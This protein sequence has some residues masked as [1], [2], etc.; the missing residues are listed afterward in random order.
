MTLAPTPAP[1]SARH[2]A[3][4][5]TADDKR[6]V[7]AALFALEHEIAASGAAGLAHEVAHARLQWWQQE[8]QQLSA[9]GARHP[10]AA[11]LE[12][13]AAKIGRPP[14]NLQPWTQAAGEQLARVAWLDRSELDAHLRRWTD[15]IWLQA[16]A[17]L[18]PPLAGEQAAFAALTAAGDA[19]REIELLGVLARDARQGR[20]YLPLDALRACNAQTSDCYAQ[21]WPAPLAQL[22]GDRLQSARRALTA[23]ANKVPARYWPALRG[24]AAWMATAQRQSLRM[25][26]ALP[27]QWNAQ[28]DSFATAVAA[29]WAAWRAARRAQRQRP[30]L[31][32]HFA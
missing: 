6:E 2:T 3:W 1:G 31:P 22:V 4:L 16:A 25:Q 32:H 10:L 11:L 12:R 24:L 26:R 8:A 13:Q 19:L 15:G 17:L 18:M 7:L 23:A 5:Y 20:L 30:P 9:G 28:T 14:P 21:P 29:N 27:L